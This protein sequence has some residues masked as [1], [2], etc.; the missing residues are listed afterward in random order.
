MAIL[1]LFLQSCVPYCVKTDTFRIS[2]LQQF[3]H[4]VVYL[5]TKIQN[6][7][8]CQLHYFLPTGSQQNW[9]NTVD[10]CYTTQQRLEQSTA[11][12]QAA[13]YTLPSV[14]IHTWSFGCVLHATV[15]IYKH[16]NTSHTTWLVLCSLQVQP[17]CLPNNPSLHKIIHYQ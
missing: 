12:G 15:C 8:T 6:K 5:W 14:L 3:L 16:L 11:M 13:S 9:S 4:T 7:Q 1:A 17:F 2:L 10:L